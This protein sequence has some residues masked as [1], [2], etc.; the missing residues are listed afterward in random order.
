MGRISQA[1]TFLTLEEVLAVN[2]ATIEKS[3]GFFVPPDN[4]LNANSLIWVLR[5]VQNSGAFGHD[6]YPQIEDK[7]SL[8]AWTIIN[9]HVFRDGNKRTGMIAMATFLEVNQKL[10]LVEDDAIIEMALR[11]AT[12]RE[13]GFSREQLA[14]WIAQKIGRQ[15]A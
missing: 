6:P 1:I 9:N 2:R 14:A 15:V 7:A 11:V 12:Y 8:I 3:G 4:L 5:V 10:L 13:H